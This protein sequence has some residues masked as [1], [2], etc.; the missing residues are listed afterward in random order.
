MNDVDSA[1]P[2]SNKSEVSSLMLL[3]PRSDK[4]DGQQHYVYDY[5]ILLAPLCAVFSIFFD[6]DEKQC[7][8]DRL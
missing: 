5:S 1:Y 4:A 6:L 7:V 8:I 2:P 3:M